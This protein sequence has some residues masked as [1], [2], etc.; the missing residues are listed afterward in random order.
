VLAAARME[1]RASAPV[2]IQLDSD[3]IF[4]REPDFSL[5]E[6]DAAARPVDMKGMCT[7]GEAILRSTLALLCEL[8]GVGYEGIPWVTSTVDRWRIASSP[9]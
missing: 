2:L 8:L 9:A 4:V 1:H 3:T 7:E 6:V 5:A